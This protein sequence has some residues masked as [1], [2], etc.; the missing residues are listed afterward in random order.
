MTRPRRDKSG[1]ASR[2]YRLLDD[3]DRAGYIRG[4]ASRLDWLRLKAAT[5]RLQI[6]GNVRALY[7]L[8]VEIHSLGLMA[9]TIAHARWQGLK[10]G[11]EQ[12]MGVP[13][14]VRIAERGATF[15]FWRGRHIQ[16]AGPA[17]GRAWQR[18]ESDD[19]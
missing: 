17:G 9:G 1:V 3:I 14:P 8:L 18:R 7:A 11:L 4:T 16:Q 2:L 6:A 13:T 5:G 12:I 15:L 10:T 19:A